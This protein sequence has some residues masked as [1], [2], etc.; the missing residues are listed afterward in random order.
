[1]I[2]TPTGTVKVLDFGLA[3]PAEPS[4]AQDLTHSP[5][6]TGDMTRGGVLLGTAA[7]MSPEQARGQLVDKRA[8][9]WAFGCVL[10][11]MLT[12][13]LAFA[14]ATLTDTLAAIVDREPDW[15]ALPPS[16]PPA[17][18][19]LLRRCLNKN[20]KRRQRDIGDAV[21]DLDLAI[22]G[23]NKPALIVAGRRSMLWPIA[24]LIALG[25]AGILAVMMWRGS[26]VPE[27]DIVLGP[28]TR[29]TADA[30]LTTEPSISADGRLVAYA[31]NR[32]GEG[33][34]DVYVQQ[35]TGGAAIRLTADSADDHQPDVSP[36]GSLVAFRSGRNPPGVYVASTLGGAARLIARDGMKPRFSPDGRTIA[37]WTGPMLAPRS[38]G[39]VRR[40]F[41]VSTAGGTPTPIAQDLASSG[42]PAWS[43]DGSGL[44]VLGRRTTSGS[45]TEADWWWVPLSGGPS[46]PS[47]AYRTFT[48]HHIVIDNTDVLPYPESWTTDGVV[49]SARAATTDT[50]ALWRIAIDRTGRV[51]GDPV[52]LT[53][54]TTIDAAPSVARDGRMVFAALNETE[55]NFALPLDA[56]AGRST[57]PLKRVRDDAAPTGRASL[58]EDGRSLL[59][60]KYEFD[61]GG[62]WLRDLQTGHE[63]QLVA[64]PRTPLNPVMSVDGRWG[65]Y[66]V[67]DV[68]T[69]GNSGPGQGFVIET[70]G[71][72]PQKVCESC[73]VAM[74]TRNTQIVVSEA[75]GKTLA[76]IEPRS[77]ARL[78]LLSSS[79]GPMDRPMFGPSGAWVTFNIPGK[80]IVAPV[81]AQ[82]PSPEAEWATVIET[83]GAGRTAGLS[84]DGGLLYVLLVQDGFRCL[85]AMKIDAATG[86]PRGE[87]FPV[88]HFHD[89]ARAWGSTGLGSAVATGIFVADLRE[90]TGNVWVT[91][92]SRSQ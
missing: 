60:P 20:L 70:S 56:N 1:M 27:S 3:R 26:P 23:L 40:S 66:T 79:Q 24:A 73:E 55:L 19:E 4:P 64:T 31:S 28:V 74:W 62:L 41:V 14:G 91:D 82:A 58:S 25:I 51:T 21:L 38:V 35:T 84:P 32:S 11:E 49:F 89:S 69:G 85:Y 78:P 65:A 52:R 17:V 54:G 77:G 33:N 86:R 18:S 59:F 87:L 80:V 44:I 9:I 8:D 75:A 15:A 46:V 61:A 30:G 10:Y 36:D 29:L 37:F 88:F 39:S 67:T 43:P 13:R 57:G 5:T 22:D 53:N 50:R 2:V 63:R 16:T 48:E 6:M 34:L 76:R 72:V 92:L 68:E 7:Y 83:G 12:R 47:G 45:G 90:T 71:G 42:D 81:H